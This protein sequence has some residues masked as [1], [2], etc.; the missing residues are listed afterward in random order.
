MITELSK[1]DFEQG[2]HHCDDV[3]SLYCE[4]LRCYLDEFSPLL[5]E[6]TMLANEH[7]AKIRIHTL[8]SLTATIG[9][10]AF[11]EFIGQLFTKWPNLTDNEK[12]Q[13]VRQIN[14]F[15]FEVNQKVQHFFNEN[16]Q[17]D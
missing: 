1:V 17:A 4:V 12:R 9:A 14:Y 11:S 5:N 8:K 13:E 15:L 3:L 16:S 2:L 10:Y 7:E 6:G